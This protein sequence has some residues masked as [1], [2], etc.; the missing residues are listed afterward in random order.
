MYIT[1]YFHR[2]I[3]SPLVLSPKRSDVHIIVPIV[4]AVYNVL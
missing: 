2:A 4:A 1:H 3:M